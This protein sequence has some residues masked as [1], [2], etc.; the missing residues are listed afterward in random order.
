M[1]QRNVTHWRPRSN[2]L[3][4]DL[5]Y[6]WCFEHYFWQR[7]RKLFSGRGYDP[8]DQ[9]AGL[10]STGRLIEKPFNPSGKKM[11][12]RDRNLNPWQ[13][14]AD[15]RLLPVSLS[16]HGETK[17]RQSEGLIYVGLQLLRRNENQEARLIDNGLNW[18]CRMNEE[19]RFIQILRSRAGKGGVESSRRKTAKPG[20]GSGRTHMDI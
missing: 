20:H 8:R 2:V 18:L 16:W 7:Q 3:G 10:R 6:A 19:K 13:G 12:R 17:P 1:V 15:E 4:R 9:D 5:N 14:C 11:L